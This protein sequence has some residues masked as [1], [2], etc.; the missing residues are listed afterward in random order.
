VFLHQ[1]DEFILDL[2]K[3]FDK[4]TKSARTVECRWFEYHIWKARK[5]GDLERARKLTIERSLTPAMDY[6]DPNF[7]KLMYVRYADDWVIGVRGSHSETMDIL[8]KI[9]EFCKEI[10]LELS[11]NKTKVTNLNKDSALFLGTKIFRSSH[12]RYSRIGNLKWIRRNR[13]KLRLEAPIDRIKSK[14]TTGSFIKFN[15]AH[16]KFLWLHLEHNQII[17][18]YNSVLRGFLNYYKFVHNYGRVA[19]YT[20]Y[21]LKQSCAKLLATKFN[22][23]TMAKVYK[24]FGGNMAGPNNKKKKGFMI[25]S[26]KITF[27]FLTAKA[28]PVIPMFQEKTNTVFKNLECSICKS[29]YKV[30]FHHVRAMKDLNPKISYMDKLM[31]KSNRK[32]IALCRKCHMVKHYP[33][34]RSK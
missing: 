15:K 31:V 10:G 22:L 5:D 34:T 21:I 13:L 30:E 32:R 8:N 25:P 17:A 24:K 9:S 2:K 7:K 4:G 28:N 18:L 11:E 27:K 6:N 29:N 33:K 20:T 16:P 19:S 12:R 23:G 3:K 26:Y 14:L 1:L